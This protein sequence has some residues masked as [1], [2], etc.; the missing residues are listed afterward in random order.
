MSYIVI[1]YN[2]F[3]T[4]DTRNK[5]YIKK[6]SDQILPPPAQPIPNTPK[7]LHFA[8]DKFVYKSRTHV[9]MQQ[10]HLFHNY[11]GQNQQHQHHVAGTSYSVS[12]T[13]YKT[14]PI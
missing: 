13:E 1:H 3:A 9:C 12:A 4:T 10:K 5:I 8:G 14:V 2:F 7:P 11:L 6:I